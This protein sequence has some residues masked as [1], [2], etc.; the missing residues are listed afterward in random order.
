MRFSRRIL[1]LGFLLILFGGLF[2][3][4]QFFSQKKVNPSV[5]VPSGKKTNVSE[6]TQEELVSSTSIFVPYW[7]IPE[8]PEDLNQ[9]D[10][11]IYFGLSPNLNGINR[12]DEGYENMSTF[13]QRVPSSKELFLGVRMLDNDTNL[14]ILSNEIYAKKVIQDAITIAQ[15][16]GFD[17][18]VLD[19][20]VFSLFNPNVP[21]QIN[22][23]VQYFYTQTNQ[24]NISLFMTLYGDV[25]YRPR[26]YN[27]KT[28]AENVDGILI[29]AYD[30]HK[31]N[32]EP[33]PN[34]PLTGKEKYG[35]DMETMVEDFL[36]DAPAKK[37]SVLFGMYGYDWLVDEKSR[38]IRPG[39][40]LSLVDIRKDFLDHCAWSNCTAL[41]DAKSKETE[42]SYIDAYEGYHKVWFEDEESV[43]EKSEFLKERGIGQTGYWVYG[44]F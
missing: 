28:L 43:K 18:I 2:A 33:G 16:N 5:S 27:V 4:S 30:F 34:F 14:T 23:F 10:R 13:L 19:L 12:D 25:Y 11:V 17:G 39:K 42:V 32:G 26:P 8:N 6:K 15:E 22:S 38:P 44:Y 24:H 29:M 21:G 35:Y 37:I 40:A 41:R 1:V 36:Q 20:E 7:N 9:Y 3:W 31:T